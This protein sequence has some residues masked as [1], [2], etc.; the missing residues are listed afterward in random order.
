MK[1]Y[2]SVPPQIMDSLGEGNFHYATD[3]AVSESR[4]SDSSQRF[5]ERMLVM[6]PIFCQTLSL[7]MLS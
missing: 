2:F 5:Q 1:T 4:S 7:I 3:F 6:Y